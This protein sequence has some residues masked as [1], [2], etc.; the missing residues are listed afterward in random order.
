MK[1]LLLIL[2]GA[3]SLASARLLPYMLSYHDTV[4][5]PLAER[6][7]KSEQA[8]DFDG[9]RIVNGNP[10]PLG[11]HP[12]MVGLVI[13]MPGNFNSV[14]GSSMLSNTRSLTAAHCWFD[15]S[16]QALSFTLAFGTT[17]VFVGG[18]RVRTTNVQMHENWSPINFSNDIAI[19]THNWVTYTNVIQP[20]A[21]PSGSLLDND[22]VGFWAQASGYGRTGDEPHHDITPNQIMREA[23]L[24]VIS[25]N[26]CRNA[27]GSV[28]R[29]TILCTSGAE[30]SNICNSD[31]GGPLSIIDNNRRVLIGVVMFGSNRCEGRLPGGYSRV[32]AYNNW[33]RARL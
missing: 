2:L 15:G 8:R 29:N 31:S 9:S 16:R 19:I 14:C 7:K 10:A 28:V 32:T 12:Y 4:G 20:I 3:V 23:T 17:T 13:E 6:L 21:L 25:N 33:I 22:F 26:E 27:Y 5:I 24:R 11:A 18:V 1:V 30:G